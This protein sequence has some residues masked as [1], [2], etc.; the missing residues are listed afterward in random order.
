MKT[1]T[2][3]AVDVAGEA[4]LKRLVETIADYMGSRVKIETVMVLQASFP[5]DRA[6]IQSIFN[7]LKGSKTGLNQVGRVGAPEKTK[8]EEAKA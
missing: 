4:K 1:I 7:R 6:D 3:P 2:F 5:D 8:K